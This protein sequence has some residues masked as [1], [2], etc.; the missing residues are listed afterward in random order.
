QV[1][2]PLVGDAGGMFQRL[3]NLLGWSR[4]AFRLDNCARCN[5]VNDWFD[6]RAPW[7]YSALQH[8]QYVEH[9]T[10]SAGST[11]VVAL[12]GTALRRL[13]HLEHAKDLRVADWHGAIVRDPTDRYWVVPTFHPSF[14]QRGAHNLIGTVL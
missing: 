3:L 1:G 7:Y 14:L 11:V 12:G 13:L 9:E 4:D 10:L 8:C 6:P 5:P 2:R